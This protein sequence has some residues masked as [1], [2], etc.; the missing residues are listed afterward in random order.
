MQ[1]QQFIAKCKQ[2]LGIN[3]CYLLNY[4]CGGVYSHGGH[5]NDCTYRSIKK[6]ALDD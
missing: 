4:R 3:P 5:R 1:F 2:A 6:S